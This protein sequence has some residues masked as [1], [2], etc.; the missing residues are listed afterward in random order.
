M[1]S[2]LNIGKRA[3]TIIQQCAK[4][5]AENIR[6]GIPH[7]TPIW[8]H[9]DLTEEALDAKAA[10][11]KLRMQMSRNARLVEL[12]MA[13][14]E[15]LAKL[16]EE[17]KEAKSIARAVKKQRALEKKSVTRKRSSAGKSKIPLAER[18]DTTFL[19]KP[20]TLKLSEQIE[21]L[22]R[23]LRSIGAHKKPVTDAQVMAALPKFITPDM[24]TRT[25]EKFW[26]DN[27]SILPNMGIL[28][29]SGWEPRK[30]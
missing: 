29:R 4:I 19:L 12:S 15:R 10:A 5:N 25:P 30:K 27:R 20:V 11:D 23:C 14:K 22:L 9:P 26:A 18:T 28:E 2:V 21:A 8:P 1:I 6:D 16:R 7:P 3:P 17:K 24:T 13:S